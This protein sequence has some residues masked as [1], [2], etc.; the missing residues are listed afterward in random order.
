MA[1][2][3]VDWSED[4]LLLQGT[5]SSAAGGCRRGSIDRGIWI[6]IPLHCLGGI[7]TGA[8]AQLVTGQITASVEGHVHGG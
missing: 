4:C 8:P 3:A 7:P 2:S 1:S 6:S 5:G